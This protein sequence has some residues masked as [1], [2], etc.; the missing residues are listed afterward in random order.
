M[1]SNTTFPVDTKQASYLIHDIDTDI[2]CLNFNNKIVAI[3][4]QIGKVGSLLQSIV[5]NP[6]GGSV[7]YDEFSVR[8][9]E[10]IGEKYLVDTKFLLGNQTETGSIYEI[11]ASQLCNLIVADNPMERRPVL[12]ALALDKSL[13]LNENQRKLKDAIRCI[14]ELIQDNKAW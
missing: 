9:I 8:S 14:P 6:D 5:T 11:I 12:L 10:K 4:T 3:V 2:I 7:N 1:N 13:F